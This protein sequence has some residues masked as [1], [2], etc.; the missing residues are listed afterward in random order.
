MMTVLMTLF[1]TLVFITSLFTANFK[2]AF[3]RLWMFALTGLTIDLF[4]VIIATAAIM[5]L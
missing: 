2:I 1:G 4:L 5:Y 3:K